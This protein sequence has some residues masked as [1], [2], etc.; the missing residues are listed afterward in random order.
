MYLTITSKLH[1]E[2]NILQKL[3][4]SLEIKCIRFPAIQYGVA[5]NWNDK[6][7]VCS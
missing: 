2:V 6:A 5:H 3:A 1:K 4:Y 7:D